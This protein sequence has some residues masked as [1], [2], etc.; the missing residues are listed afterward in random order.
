MNRVVRS[1]CLVA[2]VSVMTGCAS[3]AQ[4]EV[5]VGDSLAPVVV[6]SVPALPN[7][8][9]TEELLADY[10][11]AE[12]SLQRAQY[13]LATRY[14]RKLALETRDPRLAERATRVGIFGRDYEAALETGQLWLELDPKN[15]EGRQIVTALLI[16]ASRY[17]EAVINLEQVLAAVEQDDEERYASIIRLVGREQDRDAALAITALYNERNPNDVAGVYAYAQLALRDG[18]LD[19]AEEAVG[20]LLVLKPDWPKAAILRASIL[21]TTEREAAALEY[22]GDVVR[23]QSKNAELRA[24]YARMLVD[25]RR[26]EEALAQFRR[27]LKLA[28]D[29]EESMYAAGL[30]ALRL[31]LPEEAR[32]FFGGLESGRHA[33]DANYYLG[34]IEEID[35]NDELAQRLYSRVNGGDNYLEAQVRRALLI[36]RGGDVEGGRAH[37]SA[38]QALHP[39]QR[40]RLYV[41]EGQILRSVKRH[42]E[43]LELYNRA[44]V[45]IPDNSD[46]LY[47]RAM[48]AE[49]LDRLDLLEHDL[50]AILER[51]PD[52]VEALNSLGYTLADRTDRFDEAYIYIKRAMELK[53]N[54]SHIIDSLGWVQYRM[55]RL[56]EAEQNL[57][58]ALKMQPDPEIAAHLGEVLW[59]KGDRQGARD[60]WSRALEDTPENEVLLEVMR[61]FEQ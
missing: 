26:E 47:A 43:A 50:L 27:V 3:M 38:I 41:A 29:D 32:E 13:G 8:A 55:G 58:R 23:R 24:A 31:N 56:D 6:E 16:K 46:L 36:V 2:S 7:V 25:A 20:R 61:R 11:V 35:G 59:V 4:K 53:P 10:L 12:L 45:D 28:P 34:R 30:V 40:L 19:I 33:D 52:H 17:D 60:V 18:K 49:R 22:M 54:A 39:G 57:R 44:L 51:E 37:L 48:V 15:F 9:L 21:L 1:L 14:L 42:E 5:V